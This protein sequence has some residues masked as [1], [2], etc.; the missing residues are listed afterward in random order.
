M[1]IMPS[2]PSN[3]GSRKPARSADQRAWN[4]CVGLAS[5]AWEWLIDE[6]RLTWQAQASTHRTSGQRLFVKINARRLYDS[7]KLLTEFPEPKDFS[8]GRHLKAL[9]ITNHRHRLTLKLRASPAPG[10]QFTVWGSRPLNQGISVCHWCPL[11]GPLPPA[12]GEWIDISDLYRRKHGPYLKANALQ[13]T[14]KRVIIRLR[15]ELD[16][17]SK[18]VQE[19]RALIPPPE[20]RSRSP[21]KR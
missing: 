20:P 21:K 10:G 16:D 15:E 17:G 14:G 4:A 8:S 18:T 7:K 1:A 2:K 9:V 12:D 6:Q 11:L 3:G 13:L 19:V 5:R